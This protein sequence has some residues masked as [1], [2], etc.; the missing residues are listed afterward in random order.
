MK[1]K[2]KKWIERENLKCWR[3]LILARD[4]FKCQIC[5]HKPV[6]PHIHHI[7]PKQVKELEFDIMNGIT[8]CFNHHKVGLH[9]PHMNALWFF[10]WLQENKSEQFKYLIEK[11]K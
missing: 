3:N 4:D 1:I 8:L 7:I 6:K 5:G 2:S 9:S 11:I 10:P